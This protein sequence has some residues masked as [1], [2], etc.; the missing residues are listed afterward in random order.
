MTTTGSAARRRR[1]PSRQER[2]RPYY[3]YF[4]TRTAGKLGFTW[5]AARQTGGRPRRG[6]G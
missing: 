5:A 2:K 6:T 3:V 1:I 4:C